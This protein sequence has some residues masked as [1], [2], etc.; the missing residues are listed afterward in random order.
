MAFDDRYNDHGMLL[1]WLAVSIGTGWPLSTDL[2]WFGAWRLAGV[3]LAAAGVAV[4]VLLWEAS[5]WIVEWWT[6]RKR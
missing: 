5:T 2:G 3:G 6:F 1:G 4:L